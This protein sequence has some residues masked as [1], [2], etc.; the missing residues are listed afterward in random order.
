M[1]GNFMKILI[2]GDVHWS[3]YSSI[4]RTRSEKFS[5][6]LEN[7][8][9]SVNWIEEC[10]CVGNCDYVIYLG[11]F[12]DKSEI[13]SEEISALSEIKWNKNIKHIFLCGNHEMGDKF[14]HSSSLKLFSLV[15][16]CDVIDKPTLRYDDEDCYL[17]FLPYMLEENRINLD[18]FCK[19]F[20]SKKKYIFSHNDLQIQYGQYK[21]V[22]GYTIEEIERN[23]EY[24]FNGHLHNREL[25]TDKIENVGNL[26]GQN[27]SEDAEK[28]KHGIDVLD[29]VSGNVWFFE[30]PYAF[31]FYKITKIIPLKDHAVVSATC[32]EDEYDTIKEN[33]DTNAECY[34]IQI[35]R[36]VEENKQEV[37]DIPKVN[38]SEKFRNYVLNNIGNDDLVKSELEEIL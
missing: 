31:N 4:I 6:R 29:T 7:L 35:T 24:F 13:N 8:I 17:I 23:C 5:C 37:H 21:S 20:E 18:N 34:R 32:Y 12:F 10:S 3:Q 16:N 27:F 2:V 25:V 11:D 33:L 19:G 22:N 14:H 15:P 1:N 9:Q 38:H 36:K 28:Y 26:T 30:N